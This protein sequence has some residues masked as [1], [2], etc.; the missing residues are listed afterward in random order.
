MIK[1]ATRQGTETSHTLTV[2]IKALHKS[3]GLLHFLFS[4]TRDT[5]H[6]GS[7]QMQTSFLHIGTCMSIY[8]NCCFLVQYFKHSVSATLKPNAHTKTSCPF[9]NL[10]QFGSDLIGSY[11]TNPSLISI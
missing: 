7:N 5:N 11:N 2:D 9:H 4:F 8:F 1:G 10:Q 3:N 6:K